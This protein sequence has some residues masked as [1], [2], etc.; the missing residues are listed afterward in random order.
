MKHFLFTDHITGEDFIVGAD[1]IEQAFR[2][3][4]YEFE[5]PLFITELTEE[6]AEASGLDEY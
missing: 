6:E 3:A 4:R 5:K 1:T 2:I